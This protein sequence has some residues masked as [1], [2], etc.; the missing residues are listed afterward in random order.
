MKAIF[1]TWILASMLLQGCV[2]STMIVVD[3]ASKGTVIANGK[4][5][6]LESKHDAG[7]MIAAF[8][9]ATKIRIEN[10]QNVMFSDIWKIVDRHSA[11]NDDYRAFTYEIVLPSGQVKELKFFGRSSDPLWFGRVDTQIPINIESS[12]T[13]DT[14]GSEPRRGSYLQIRCKIQSAKGCDILEKIEKYS[15]WCEG[16]NDIYLLPY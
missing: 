15:S 9:N 14:K 6:A 2:N 10:L 11:Q 4:K 5:F 7:Q 8:P 13:L 3:C 16:S 1:K 12:G